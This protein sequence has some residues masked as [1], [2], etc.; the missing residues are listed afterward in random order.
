[1]LTFFWKSCIPIYNEKTAL[2]TSVFFEY[3]Y[4][5]NSFSSA[6]YYTICLIHKLDRPWLGLHVAAANYLS[7]SRQ[8][9]NREITLWLQVHIVSKEHM[10]I[11][12]ILLHNLEIC[13]NIAVSTNTTN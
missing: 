1:M 2:I 10:C 9:K 13:Y 8:F 11:Y 6:H 12:H 4:P 7:Q 3:L 5:M